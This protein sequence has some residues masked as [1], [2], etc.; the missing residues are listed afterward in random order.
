MSTNQGN[1]SGSPGLVAQTLSLREIGA[2]LIKHYGLHEGMFEISAEFMIG[3]GPVG[4]SPDAL[5]PGASV[6]IAG[7][8][9]V[10]AHENAGPTAINAAEVNPAPKKRKSNK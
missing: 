9:L 6:G 4:P 10:R 3:M 1:T 8:G 2:L 7:I 5:V